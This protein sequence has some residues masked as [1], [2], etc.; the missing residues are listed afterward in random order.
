MCGA[1]SAP[2]TC[3][4]MHAT[5]LYC[6]ETQ[7]VWFGAHLVMI[8]FPFEEKLCSYAYYFYYCAPFRKCNSEL[9]CVEFTSYFVDLF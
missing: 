1:A 6:R 7:K 4:H 3:S 5:L 9:P 2:A 8:I